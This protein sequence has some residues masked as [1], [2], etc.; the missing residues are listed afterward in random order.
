MTG[1][2]FDAFVKA[3]IGIW[4]VAIGACILII[5]MLSFAPWLLAIVIAAITCVALY[6]RFQNK[7]KT[8]DKK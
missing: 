4:A 5:L 7:S 6:Q 2:G 3:I 8:S 1:K